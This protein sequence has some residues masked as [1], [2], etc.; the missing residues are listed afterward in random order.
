MVH[1]KSTQTAKIA[2]NQEYLLEVSK[3]SIAT[4]FLASI[5]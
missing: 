4:G 5:E 3:Q 1:S 2:E